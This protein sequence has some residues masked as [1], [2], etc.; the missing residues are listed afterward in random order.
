[1]KIL[2]LLDERWDSGLTQYALQIVELLQK[3][4][5]DVVLGVLSGKKP[6]TMA[7]AKGLK[8]ASIDS[9][10]SLSRLVRGNPWDLINVHT[11]RTHTWALLLSRKGTPIV[12]TRGDARPVRSTPLSRFVY[13]KTAAVIAASSHI[14]HYYE[15]GLGLPEERVHVIYPFVIPDE[16]STTPPA[17][18]VGILG[19]LDPVKGHAVFLEAVTDVLK[20]R[21]ET[22]FLIA[23]KEA[24]LTFD[25]LRNQMIEL[26]IEKSVE[27]LGYQASAQD[28]MRS[29]SLGVIASIGSEEI[30][31]ACLEW[32]AVGRPV[33]GTLVGCLPELIEP[34]ENGLLVPPNDGS[35]MGDAILKLLREPEK[36]ESWGKTALAFIQAKFSSQIQL[37]KTLAVYESIAHRTH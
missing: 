34:N 7:H 29:C 22:K 14:A 2:H 36:I 25:L 30:S 1:M 32:M 5:H 11:G 28:F 31:R 4:G 24:N 3:E 27:Y 23:G 9:I 15:E 37:K 10:F 21:P 16:N 8:T 6:E 26:G 13:R 35:A 33:V 17:N 20:E 12:R 18:R 19:R